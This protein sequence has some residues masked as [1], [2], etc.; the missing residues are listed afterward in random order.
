MAERLLVTGSAG[1]VGRLLR[2]RLARAGRELRLLDVVAQA[3]AAA[4]SGETLIEADVTD[5][6]A[7]TSAAEGTDAVLHLAAYPGEQIWSELQRLNVDGTR[8]VLEAARAAG[9][10]RVILFSTIHAAGYH[11]RG[12]G[13][14]PATVPAR[15]DT[16]YGW[17]KAAVEALGSLYADRFG[18][19]VFVPRLGACFPEPLNADLLDCWISP[20]DCARLVEACLA[21]DAGGFHL[22]WGISRNTRRWWSLAEGE[23]IGYHPRDDSEAYA[24]R[25]GPVTPADAGVVGGFFRHLPL[26][27]PS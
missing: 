4:G 18:M 20:D 22:L 15:P 21:T 14:L 13:F 24:D 27:E 12:D 23:A 8:N 9:V 19:A 26:G 5:L 7:M 10:S 2:P 11:R 6:A 1:R 3:E 25:L 17:S 16:Y